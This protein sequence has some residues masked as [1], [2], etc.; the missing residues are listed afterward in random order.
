MTESAPANGISIG[1]AVIAQYI[2]VANTKTGADHATCNICRN[3]PPLWQAVF[4]FH[5]HNCRYMY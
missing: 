1:S 3:R 2:S 4:T 5:I